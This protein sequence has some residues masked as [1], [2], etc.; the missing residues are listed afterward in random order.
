M[1]KVLIQL[2]ETFGYPVFLQG[3]LNDD[4]EYPKSFFTFWNFDTPDAS[5][6]DNESSR[7]EWGFT[8]YFYS[9][10]P[11]LIDETLDK[12]R[13]LLK[14]NHWIVEGRGQDAKSDVKTHTGRMITCWKVENL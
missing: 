8:V 14:E 13:R 10:D 1:K 9:D 3:S 2:L 7:S 12:A 4:D 5:Y 11:I 6:Y